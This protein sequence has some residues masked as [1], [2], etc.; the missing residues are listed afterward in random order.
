MML[1]AFRALAGIVLMAGAFFPPA[2]IYP[3]DGTDRDS[4]PP[5]PQPV[6][7]PE[8]I[9]RVETGHPYVAITV[10]DFFTANYGWDTAIR[11]LQAANK[12]HASL[13][14]CPAGSA[15]DEYSHRYPDQAAQIRQLVAEGNYEL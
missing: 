11:I 1:I 5:E 7:R 4:R 9:R 13:T 12:A 15:L 8:V 2:K 3:T 10:D 14:L 6:F